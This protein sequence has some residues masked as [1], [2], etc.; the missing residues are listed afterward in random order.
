MW[1]LPLLQRFAFDIPAS[2]ISALEDSEN[3][4]VGLMIWL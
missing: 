1:F 4:S 3:N 2:R